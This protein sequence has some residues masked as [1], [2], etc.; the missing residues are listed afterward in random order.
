VGGPNKRKEAVAE[1]QRDAVGQSK[2]S[3][4]ERWQASDVS[5]LGTANMSS[6]NAILA[7]VSNGQLNL[8]ARNTVLELQIGRIRPNISRGFQVERSVEAHWSPTS[9]RQCTH[10]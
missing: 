5:T 9:A 2:T 1:T 10:I 4:L 6:E 7:N 8:I 3:H